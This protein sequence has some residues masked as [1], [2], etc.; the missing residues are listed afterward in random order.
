MQVIIYGA[1]ITCDIPLC[2]SFPLQGASRCAVKVLETIPDNFH[3]ADFCG[4][5]TFL[6]H[7]RQVN[8]STDLEQGRDVPGAQWC[9]TVKDVV[10]L[11]WTVDSR[12]IFYE[13]GPRGNSALLTFWLV[14]LVLPLYLTLERIYVFFHAA[15]VEIEGRPVLFTAP[16]MGGKSSLVQYF[17]GRGHALVADD[18]LPTYQENG[19]YMAAPAHPFCRARRT[20]EN[21]GCRAPESMLRPKTICC[22]YELEPAGAG[23][24]VQIQKIRGMKKL[25]LLLPHCLYTLIYLQPE[26]MR[27]LADLLE[28]VPIFS[29]HLPWDLERLP[30]VYDKL[31]C[32]AASLP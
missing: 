23:D 21:L 20:F 9:Y 22:L 28:S 10:R 6:V 25:E 14:H 4:R 8:L 32:H 13:I 27:Y 7:G 30:E 11:T 1:E 29:L 16:S 24:R 3:L 15:G 12:I 18:K 31:S 2:P 19:G 5:C 17:L 26:R